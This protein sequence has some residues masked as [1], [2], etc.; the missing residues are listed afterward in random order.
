MSVSAKR[1][2]SGQRGSVRRNMKITTA[3]EGFGS[4]CFAS[5]GLFE[6]YR[7]HSMILPTALNIRHSVSRKTNRG[8][9]S[10]SA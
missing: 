8:P 1:N 9:I 5:A 7:Q 10:R 6:D 2:A 3:S 4:S